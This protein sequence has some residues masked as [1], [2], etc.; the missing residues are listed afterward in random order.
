MI[1]SVE[2]KIM[3]LLLHQ[4]LFHSSTKHLHGF[5]AGSTNYSA[6]GN[7]CPPTPNFPP[8]LRHLINEGIFVKAIVF[9]G[10]FQSLTCLSSGTC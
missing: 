1:V 9:V 8:E 2:Q 5:D 10:N 6:I 7:K 4:G 3:S